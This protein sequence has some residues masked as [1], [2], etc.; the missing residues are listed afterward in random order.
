MRKVRKVNELDVAL[1]G[2]LT[3]EPVLLHPRGDLLTDPRGCDPQLPELAALRR[4]EPGRDDGLD[5]LAHEVAVPQEVLA[6]VLERGGVLAHG[7]SREARVPAA[8]RTKVPQ[9]A[10][11]AA[12]G[13]EDDFFVVSEGG[14]DV[15]EDVPVASDRR[16]ARSRAPAARTPGPRG[17]AGSRR[18]APGRC[19]GWRRARPLRRPVAT[20][21]RSAGRG[22][23]RGRRRGRCPGGCGPPATGSRGAS[24]F[25]KGRPDSRAVQ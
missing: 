10:P 16:Q 11:V 2:V 21:W 18:R 20:C 23:P 14:V 19:A 5:G 6:D 3:H 22:H 25:R 1:E 13:C 15:A 24:H 8:L 17:T 4:G 7:N 12:K 9:G